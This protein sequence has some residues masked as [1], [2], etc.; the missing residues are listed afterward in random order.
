MTHTVTS[1]RYRIGKSI[2][3]DFSYSNLYFNKGMRLQIMLSISLKY[4]MTVIGIQVIKLF[5]SW[6]NRAVKFSLIGLKLTTNV[7]TSSQLQDNVYE[8]N[9]FT[10]GV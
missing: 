2:G 9:I 8:N 5:I 7:V 1:D 10:V 3:W 6:E 4:I